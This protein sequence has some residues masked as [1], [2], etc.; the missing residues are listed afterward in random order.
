MGIE[1]LLT[2]NGIAD[3]ATEHLGIMAYAAQFLTLTPGVMT[4]EHNYRETKVG[5]KRQKCIVK[6]M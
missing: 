4:Y 2:A 5:V 3:E 1:P 6:R